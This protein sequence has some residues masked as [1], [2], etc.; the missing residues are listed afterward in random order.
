V[1]Q[2]FQNADSAAAVIDSA[3]ALL[4]SATVAEDAARERYSAGVGSLLELLMAQSAAAQARV[5]V[6]QA[7]Y[8]ARLAVTRLGFAVG[9]RAL[10]N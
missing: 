9:A 6:V 5:S 10:P 4:R 8:D 7:R 3:E 1:W 2:S